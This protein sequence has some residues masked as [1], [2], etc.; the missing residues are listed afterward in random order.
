[1]SN[2]NEQ[3]SNKYDYNKSLHSYLEEKYE[4]EQDRWIKKQ[5]GSKSQCNR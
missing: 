3:M 5:E 2:N 4:I 1:M